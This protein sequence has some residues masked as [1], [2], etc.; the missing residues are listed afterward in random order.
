MEKSEWLN[1]QSR[2]NRKLKWLVGVV[3]VILLAGAVAGGIIGGVLGSRR[4]NNASGRSSRGSDSKDDKDG[5]LT[6]DSPEIK[7]LMG[8]PNLHKVFPGMDYTPLGAQYPE[9]LTSPPSQNDVTQD[10]AV[11]SQLTNRIRLY[12]TDCNQTE[13]VLHSIDVLDM[14]KDVKVWLGVWLDKNQTT[15]DRQL[16]HMYGILDKHGA[17]PFAGVIVGNEVL[18]RKDTTEPELATLL[19]GIR[20]NFTTKGIKL[21]LATSDLGDNWTVELASEVDI[22]MA[23]VHPFFG[24]VPVDEAAGWTWNFW[25]ERNV[26]P[27]SS[28]ANRPKQIISEVGWPTGGGN[29]CGVA[30]C[31]DKT[32]HSVSGIPQLNEFMDKFVCQSLTNGTEY[33]W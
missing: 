4:G 19:Q 5:D 11:L 16:K 23:N 33:F 22:V 10:V 21:P 18:Y 17:E 25:Q 27:T 15:N 6:K 24:G 31:V 20:T 9:C 13:M 32:S 1:R 3:I 28:L 7:S 8:N 14:K 26:K 30:V 29:N 2:G 12:G